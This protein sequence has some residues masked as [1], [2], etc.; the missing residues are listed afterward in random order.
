MNTLAEI[1]MNTSIFSRLSEFDALVAAAS[2]GDESEV[3]RLMVKVDPTADDCL[4]LNRAVNNGHLECVRALLPVSL[5]NT[6]AP[7]TALLGAIC[8]AVASEQEACLALLLEQVTPE[9]NV[10]HDLHPSFRM[11]AR[12]NH[13]GCLKLLRPYV[14]PKFNHSE[15]LY[16]AAKGMAL[17]AFDY[18]LPL[19]DITARKQLWSVVA[20]NF[21]DE[22]LIQ[23]LESVPEADLNPEM[24]D[25]IFHDSV[26][27]G[28][29][30]QV[31]FLLTYVDPKKNK[32]E[33]L[34]LALEFNDQELA[35]LLYPHSD[36]R[37]ALELLRKKGDTPERHLKRLVELETAQRLKEV[38]TNATQEGGI[39]RARKM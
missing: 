6:A 33:A 13:C 15:A 34:R 39:G 3:R 30:S 1:F 27:H 9:M 25:T 10:Q 7:R 28:Y 31:K 14:D 5:A 29:Y 36:L 21:P 2:R 23:M 32:S 8:C 22:T 19:S 37:V 4:P 18:L 16:E 35:E 24:L 12:K 17:E 11:A 20:T 38:L 26:I